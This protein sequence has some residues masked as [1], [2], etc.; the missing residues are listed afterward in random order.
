[1]TTDYSGYYNSYEVGDKVEMRDQ[2]DNN[3]LPETGTVYEKG[4]GDETFVNVTNEKG[5]FKTGPTA[6]WK[7]VK[8]IEKAKKGW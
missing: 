6:E 2:W 7:I 8:V 3:N 1:M 5:N 4:N